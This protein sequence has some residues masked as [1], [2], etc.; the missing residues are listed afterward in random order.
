MSRL[1]IFALGP[2]RIELDGQVV[3][4]S[5][6]KALALLL[7][8]AAMPGTHTRETLSGLLWPE[9]EQD[10]AYAYLRRALWELRS[11]LGEDWLA[12][13]SG[14][15]SIRPGAGMTLDLLDFQS[16]LSAFRRHDHPGGTICQE[17][18]ANLQTAALL[19]RGDFLAGF[20]LRDSPAFEDWQFFQAEG[21]R[22]EY[23]SVL[24]QLTNLIFLAGATHEAAGFARRWLAL[25][26]LNEEAHRLL[27]RIYARSG[28]RHQA[29]RQYQECQQIL[30][31]ELGAAPEPA[32]RALHEAIV[33]GR[34]QQ[35]SALPAPGGGTLNAWLGAA[36]LAGEARPAGG[37][38]AAATPLVGRRQ[39]LTEIAALLADPGCWLVTLLGPGGIGKTRLA[40][41]VGREQA[42]GFP[43]GAYLIPLSAVKDRPSLVFG[44]ARA[45][46]LV[47]R[48]DGR[49]PEEQVLDFL[50]EKH[51]LLILDSFE[52]LAPW[53]GWL[54]EMHAQAA[55]VKMLVTSRHRLHLP[56]EW[57]LEVKG[58]EVP[59]EGEE[60][61][62]SD[63]P[64][65]A[66]EMFLQ[67]ARR[68]W[69]AF[70]PGAE[71]LR[72]IR[73]VARLLEGMPLG[74]ELAAAWVNTL[75]CAEIAEEIGRGLDILD[76]R[77]EEPHSLRAVFERSWNLLS[78][79]EQLIL[80]RLAVF[81]GGFT[82]LAAE[83]TAGTALRELLG[84]VDKS[85]LR[86]APDGR[87]DLHDLLR[88]YC[89]E[90][91]D[92]QPEEAH[93]TRQ[94]HCA[95]Y[96]A[97]LEQWNAGL[98]GENQGRILGEIESELGNLQAA[99][100]WA[101]GE[102]RLEYLAQAADG[103][104]TF[105]FRRARFTEGDEAL[106]RAVEAVRQAAPVAD[107]LL[108]SGLLARLLTWQALLSMNQER[109]DEAD[110][111]L[112]ECSPLLDDPRLEMG[113]L[114][115]ERIFHDCIR[116][117]LAN[118]RY[119][120]A[121]TI[122]LYDR[123]FQLSRQANGKWPGFLIYNWRFLMGGAVSRE[124]YAYIEQQQADIQNVGDP[125]ELGCYL[126]VLGIAALYHYFHMERAEALLGE[127]CACF[128]VMDDPT[129]QVMIT[130]T[131]GYLLLARGQFTK[132]GELKQR[133]LATLEHLGDR[134]MVGIALAEIGE[135]LYHQGLYAAAEERLRA[136]MALLREL[137]PYEYALRHRYLGDILLA[138][139]RAEEARAAC[140][141]SQRFFESV[142][143]K[144]WTMTALI[145]LS[146]TELALDD[147]TAAWEHLRQ[148]LRLYGEMQL[149]TYFVYLGL[150]QAGLLLAR[151]GKTVRG[152]E[153]YGLALQQ[154]QLARS[155]WF[156]E[157]Y[158][159][160]MEQAAA[161]LTT[162]ERSAALERGRG[163]ELSGV[164][165]GL[166]DK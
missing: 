79:R 106:R 151:E 64:Y 124:L 105:Y 137:S 36:L 34:F 3:Q 164:L 103:L 139:G 76:V 6:H 60:E 72:S 82:R 115:Q 16:H 97:R 138:Q 133:E 129:T 5:R 52:Y 136:G 25:D 44:T 159:Q 39:E 99:W 58:L 132:F 27:M 131:L 88:Q 142:H 66:V 68:A 166:A 14:Q 35:E 141:F 117:L 77:A 7:Y 70:Q 162:E 125:F 134:R 86:R 144:G 57:V 55:G 127:C 24:Q 4:T 46:G 145:G 107:P 40:L 22:R 43:H 104:G 38:P 67:A 123:A 78:R 100:E 156:A 96:S 54:E 81:H 92:A 74:L 90:K 63:Q 29:L 119:D 158:G 1:N 110:Q 37:L 21:L 83:P 17:C 154:E 30:R 62:L 91:L 155:R 56:G 165:A 47:F 50:R 118:R 161:A 8:L 140:Q 10:K 51:L 15:L 95:Y 102:G 69:T 87:F 45:L 26:T 101:A 93:Q 33:S 80:S 28:Q 65:S 9:Y 148:A 71:E 146:R 49:L 147:C 13:E 113:Q 116:A 73:Q 18:I 31:Q 53:A 12:A 19:Y 126:F 108:A 121:A 98:H 157:V 143:E 20:S 11:L 160:A 61:C 153:L 109:F 149:Y 128:Q 41:E 114:V 111:L 75:S 48:Q 135:G 2:L 112:E 150:A 42:A 163:L 59:P 23:A 84:L 32:T 85:L 122:V 89:R 94:R 120:T 130:K 152:L